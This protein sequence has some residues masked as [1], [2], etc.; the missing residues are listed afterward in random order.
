MRKVGKWLLRGM[1]ALVLAGGLLFANF[2]YFKP[3]SINWFYNR[4]FLQYALDDPELLSSLRLFEPL[5]IQSHNRKL[6]DASPAHEAKLFE[7]LKRD[8]ATLQR[9]D[10]S[11]FTGQDA[12]SYD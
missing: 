5:G 7:K 2:W 9:Y 3:L 1:L 11:K 12:L 6:T 8:Y 10:H 4:V